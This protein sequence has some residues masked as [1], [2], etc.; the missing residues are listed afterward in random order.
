MGSIEIEICDRFV[1]PAG[2]Q[3]KSSLVLSQAAQR[4]Q[5]KNN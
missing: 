1:D 3:G 2:V 4:K 5:E